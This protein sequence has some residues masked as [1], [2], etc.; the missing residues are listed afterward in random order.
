VALR[1]TITLG[2]KNRL[3]R[4]KRSLD[5]EAA[6]LLALAERQKT[7]II[8]RTERGYD[9]HG[10]RFIP[11][12]RKRP[13]YYSPNPALPRPSRKRAAARFL[14]KVKHRAKG[15]RL[16]R[17][18]LTVR[19]ENYA[20]FKAALGRQPGIVDLT[21]PRAPHMLQ[22]LKVTLRGRQMVISPYDAEKA[23]IGQAHNRGVRGRLP[24]REWFGLSK[25]DRRDMA[26]EALALVRNRILGEGFLSSPGQYLKA[27]FGFGY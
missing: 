15:A 3:V 23:R 4:L 7:R 1:L 24:K 11:Y 20:A 9:L 27:R 22:T 14:S 10:V 8:R 6:E 12:S 26:K 13:Y 18:G 2:D 21:G 16:S 25:E 19:F 5:L 17:S